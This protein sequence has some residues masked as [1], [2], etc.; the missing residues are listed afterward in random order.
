M[1]RRTSGGGKLSDHATAL[2]PR[3]PWEHSGLHADQMISHIGKNGIS[4]KTPWMART[5]ARHLLTEWQATAG[6]IEIAEL[7]T[8]ELVTNAVR[9]APRQP[10]LTGYVPYIALAYWYAPDL[11][12]IEV[13]DNNEKPPELQV[14]DE[15]SAGGRGLFLVEALSREWSYYF[16][17]KG[18]KTVYCVIGELRESDS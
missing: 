14:A 16:P 6:L 7:L 2:Q 4:L 5:M 18:W 13:S 10:A 11:A 3:R 15:E 8:S 17:R 1:T 12:I 9:R